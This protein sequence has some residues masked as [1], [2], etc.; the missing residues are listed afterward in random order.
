M[1]TEELK[2]QISALKAQLDLLSKQLPNQKM[3]ERIKPFFITSRNVI[4]WLLPLLAF[5]VFFVLSY[6]FLNISQGETIE[7][8]RVFIWPVTT[9][10]ILFF[11]RKIFTYLF[12]SMDEFN[13]FGIKGSLRNVQD[14]INE[15]ASELRNREKEESQRKEKV[16]LFE[17]EIE[18]KQGLILDLT[19]QKQI[20]VKEWSSLAEEFLQDYKKLS[21]DYVEISQK[22]IEKLKKEEE[23]KIKR[24]ALKKIIEEHGRK[25]EIRYSRIPDREG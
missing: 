10:I 6:F 25:G 21:K 23:E 4:I 24:D 11:F 15:K 22:Y 3:I 19:Q 20:E 8:L 9:L 16:K 14:V 13:F 1:I 5:P 18:K 2:A 7:L 12:F 17:K